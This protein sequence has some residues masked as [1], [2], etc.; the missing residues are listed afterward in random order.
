LIKG[1]LQR[2]APAVE[3]E[4]REAKTRAA[5]RA[6]ELELVKAAHRYRAL[7]D[8]SP[9]PTWVCEPGTNEFIAVNDAPTA[10]YGYSREEFAALRL[11]DLELEMP[12][13]LVAPSAA[14][15]DEQR[16]SALRHRKRD[17][18]VIWVEL[19]T[20]ELEL[21]GRLTRLYVAQDVTDRKQ[22]EALLRKTEEQ[23]RQAQKMEASGSR[24]CALR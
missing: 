18:S 19:T 4:I 23:L 24:K 11:A 13:E 10:H 17:G 6:A 9:L 22:A 1:H 8:G 15:A 16:G 3:R 14:T 12:S 7:F 5:R 21:E 2:L 20:H